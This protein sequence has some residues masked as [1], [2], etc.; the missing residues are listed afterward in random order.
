MLKINTQ[1]QTLS[2]YQNNKIIAKYPISSAKNGLGETNSSECT[3]RGRHCICEK[4][5]TN[6]PI[7]SVFVARRITGEIYNEKLALKYPD[8][9]W[10]LTRILWLSGLE[11][12]NKNTK[13]RYIYI[14]GMPDDK[15]I[16]IPNS[17][18]CIRMRNV[19]I[20]ELFELVCENDQVIIK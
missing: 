19:D 8:R 1:T 18:G 5:G 2:Y 7:N 3:P 4:I 12:Y 17:K 11:K 15:P 6:L 14:H 13:Q 20:V 9:D 10:I 16:N